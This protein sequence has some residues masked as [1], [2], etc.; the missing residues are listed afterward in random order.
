MTEKNDLIFELIDL[1]A[2]GVK[3]CGSVSFAKLDIAE[4][5][6]FSFP[7]ALHYDLHLAPCGGNNVLLR[8]KLMA[9]I[10]IVCDRCDQPGQL[11]LECTDVC[12]TYEEAYGKVLDLTPDIREDI[13]ITF[14]QK[15]LCRSDCLG[16][17]LHCGQDLNKGTCGCSEQASSS[18]EADP[19][20]SLD[21]LHLT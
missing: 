11:A 4:E 12:H 9:Q 13:L 7:E 3:I 5:A 17:C 21:Q 19:W 20:R 6:Q 2:D 18:T 15:F 16:L 8:G 14:P 1:P 10:A